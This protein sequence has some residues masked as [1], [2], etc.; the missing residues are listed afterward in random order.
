[1]K[2]SALSFGLG[3]LVMLLVTAAIWPRYSP[4]TP[5]QIEAERFLT[6]TKQLC[7]DA[8]LRRRQAEGE[9]LRVPFV[10]SDSP[11]GSRIYSLLQDAK[12]DVELYC[13]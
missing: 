11:L 2:R 5:A 12:A 3:V 9:L 8:L 10:P 4:T 1:M 13:Q 6:V 7:E